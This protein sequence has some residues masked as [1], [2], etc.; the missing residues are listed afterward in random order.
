[1]LIHL[2][3]F[4]NYSDLKPFTGFIKATFMALETLYLMDIYKA[5]YY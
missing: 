4:N 2:T 5:G 3:L 1:M